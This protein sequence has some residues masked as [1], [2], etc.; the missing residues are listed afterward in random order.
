MHRHYATETISDEQLDQLI[1]RSERAAS[2]IGWSDD[3]MLVVAEDEDG[4]TDENYDG[5]V[6]NVLETLGMSNESDREEH[7]RAPDVDA[8][9][10]LPVVDICG[11]TLGT[12]YSSLNRTDK[13][14]KLDDEAVT[15]AIAWAILQT[16]PAWVRWRLQGSVDSG[17]EL[18][19]RP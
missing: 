4:D 11:V 10:I 13:V 1:E 3:D 19:A 17:V 9:D 14:I 15:S 16:L 2:S 8:G 6:W 7:L 12:I 5:Y 18:T